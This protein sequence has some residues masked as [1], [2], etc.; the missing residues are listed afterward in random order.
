MS[1]QDLR[2]TGLRTAD[3]LATAEMMLSSFCA[4]WMAYLTAPNVDDQR[5][6]DE[7]INQLSH[8]A[9]EVERMRTYLQ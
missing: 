8:V 4:E 7:L 1:I 5:Q 9:A 2:R 6:V 3:A